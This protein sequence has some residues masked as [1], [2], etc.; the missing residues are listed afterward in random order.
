M[1]ISFGFAWPTSIIKSYKARTTQGKSLPF[2]IIILFGY[3]CGIVSKFLFGKYDFIGHFTQY[4]VLIF[5][6]I[7]FIMVGFDLFLYYRNYKLDQSA[8]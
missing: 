3:A 6:I 5:Y 4:Y 1:V 7:N 8:K 2:L